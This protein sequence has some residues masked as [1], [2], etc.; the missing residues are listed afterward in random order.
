MIANC[1]SRAAILGLIRVGPTLVQRAV[2]GEADLARTLLGAVSVG[3]RV[4]ADADV[5]VAAIY[6]G[7]VV[8]RAVLAGVLAVA[9]FEEGLR[10]P[11]ACSAPLG[12]A[13]QPHAQVFVR[14]DEGVLLLWGDVG[15][16]GAL[17]HLEVAGDLVETELLSEGAVVPDV[18]VERAAG[19]ALDKSVVN[20]SGCGHQ[21]EQR[22]EEQACGVHVEV[23][24]V[25]V[26]RKCVCFRDGPRPCNDMLMLM[27]RRSPAKL[28]SSFVICPPPKTHRTARTMGQ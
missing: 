2:P 4:D 8:R 24:T 10:L 3:D 28:L 26:L 7:E 13:G 5:L 1:I 11:L 22:G 9:E 12:V 27:E 19:A 14:G 15:G 21:G 18:D 20:G 23:E 6:D 17:E 25:V 16:L